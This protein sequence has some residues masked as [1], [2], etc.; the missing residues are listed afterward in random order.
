MTKQSIPAMWQKPINCSLLVSNEKTVWCAPPDDNH[1]W[2]ASL[3]MGL[4]S[5]NTWAT[6]SCGNFFRTGTDSTLLTIITGQ[7]N[8]ILKD[9]IQTIRS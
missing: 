2:M 9:L 8:G 1:E 7:T 6:G 3:K 5:R 4:I